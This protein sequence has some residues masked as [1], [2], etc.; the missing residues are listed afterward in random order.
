MEAKKGRSCLA[1]KPLEEWALGPDS[2]SEVGVLGHKH[3]Q[4]W[5]RHQQIARREEEWMS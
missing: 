5:A 2:P 1:Q 3:L 4:S